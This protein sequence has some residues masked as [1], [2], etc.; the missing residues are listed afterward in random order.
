MDHLDNS[1]FIIGNQIDFLYF[2]MTSIVQSN[3]CCLV[4]RPF[5]ESCVLPVELLLRNRNIYDLGASMTADLCCLFMSFVA[6]YFSFAL[7]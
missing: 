7:V 4:G 2:K 1:F 3:D 6:L 5:R